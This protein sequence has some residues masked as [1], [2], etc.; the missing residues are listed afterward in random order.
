MRTV[1]SNL[2]LQYFSIV[3]GRSMSREAIYASMKIRS[4]FQEQSRQLRSLTRKDFVTF[5]FWRCGP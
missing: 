2:K 4:G 5:I 1:I 3:M